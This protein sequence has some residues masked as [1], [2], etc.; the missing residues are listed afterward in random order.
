M[1]QV[2]IMNRIVICIHFNVKSEEK[3]IGSN[4]TENSN[5]SRN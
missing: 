4:P 3:N 2:T 1:L 5:V